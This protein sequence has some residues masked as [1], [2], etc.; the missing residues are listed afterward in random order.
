MSSWLQQQPPSHI[1]EKARVTECDT[2]S[3]LYCQIQLKSRRNQSVQIFDTI[4]KRNT[5]MSQ[6]LSQWKAPPDALRQ[7]CR[8]NDLGPH[9]FVEILH[10]LAARRRT[11]SLWWNGP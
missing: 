1:Y 8:L 7:Q 3:T 10:S 9:V 6:V 2:D 5:C 4:C 11:R